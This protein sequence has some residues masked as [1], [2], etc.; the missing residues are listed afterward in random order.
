MYIITT[1]SGHFN[2][3]VMLLNSFFFFFFSRLYNPS[4]FSACSTIIEHSQ[5]EGFTEFYRV[6]LAV[7]CLT[8]NLEENQGFRAFQL[9]PQEAPSF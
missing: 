4:G 2:K 6:L 7:A 9:S 5:Q 1:Q 3:V 8:P